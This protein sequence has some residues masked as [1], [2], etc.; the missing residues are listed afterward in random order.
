M[1]LQSA[2]E[3]GEFGGFGVDGA[4]IVLNIFDFGSNLLTFKGEE[5]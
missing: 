3:L 5:H 2:K 4:E 1:G